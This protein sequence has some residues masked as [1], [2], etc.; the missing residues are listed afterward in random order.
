M[1][2][3][4][5]IDEIILDNEIGKKCDRENFTSKEV[6]TFLKKETDHNRP[7]IFTK[8]NAYKRKNNKINN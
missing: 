4:Y 6:I 2:S 5:R 3:N 8:G 1:S 7:K